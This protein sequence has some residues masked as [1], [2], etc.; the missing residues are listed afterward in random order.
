M[1]KRRHQITLKK[2]RKSEA[3]LLRRLPAGG[4]EGSAF[5]AKC[6]SGAIRC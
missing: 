1:I 4:G 2:I 6:G 3:T 5:D